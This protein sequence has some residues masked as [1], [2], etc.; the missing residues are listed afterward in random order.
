MKTKTVF[1]SLIIVAFSFNVK[2]QI[3][4]KKFELKTEQMGT[5]IWSFNAPKYAIIIQKGDTLVNGDLKIE[6]DTI[7]LTNE[8]GQQA[9]PEGSV[10]KYKFSIL[11][12]ELK[13]ELIEDDCMGRANFITMLWK[14]IAE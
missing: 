12:K 6:K 3:T 9:C 10:G 8:K 13:M 2:A 14:Q 11:N 4:G 7:V 5:L 1:F